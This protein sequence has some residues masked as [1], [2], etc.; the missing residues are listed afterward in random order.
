MKIYLSHTEFPLGENLVVCPG[1]Q[2]P[3]AF[4]KIHLYSHNQGIQGIQG[5]D[6]DQYIQKTY[7]QYHY[8][9]RQHYSHHVHVLDILQKKTSKYGFETFCAIMLQVKG[10]LKP[11]VK[12][13]LGHLNRN[14]S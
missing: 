1:I 2:H 9:H 6:S 5:H 14:I 7:I 3:Q 8:T 10:C 13:N 12:M 4:P 11:A